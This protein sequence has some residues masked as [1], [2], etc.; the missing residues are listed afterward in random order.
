MFPLKIV[1]CIW[2]QMGLWAAQSARLIS[3][4]VPLEICPV[5]YLRQANGRGTFWSMRAG[6]ETLYG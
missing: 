1:S 5:A 3:S 4:P 6:A 2:L